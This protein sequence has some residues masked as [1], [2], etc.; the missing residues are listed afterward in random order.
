MDPYTVRILSMCDGDHTKQKTQNKQT[1]TTKAQ[2]QQ[3][4]NKTKAPN[5]NQE[6]PTWSQWT[7]QLYGNCSSL[8]AD[9]WALHASKQHRHQKNHNC[10]APGKGVKRSSTR[11]G[12]P[13]S[14]QPGSRRSQ[15]DAHRAQQAP[16]SQ[17]SYHAL[18]ERDIGPAA[19]TL[20][21]CAM[22]K[23]MQNKKCET[24]LS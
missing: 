14:P 22:Q 17:D 8:C 11:C 23:I 24:E 21:W 12:N 19:G 10:K 6:K 16:Q 13:G 18:H 3:K 7:N 9:G 20:P 4:Q 5:K 1:K 15:R 2:T